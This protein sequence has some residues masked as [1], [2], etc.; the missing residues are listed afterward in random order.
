[1]HRINLGYKTETVWV[2]LGVRRARG[3]REGGE[4]KRC[5]DK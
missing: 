2:G 4:K 1:M 3:I 5:P